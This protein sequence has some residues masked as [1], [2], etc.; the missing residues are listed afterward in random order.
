LGITIVRLPTIRTKHLE[1]LIHTFLSTIHACFSNCDVVHYYT[2]GP[3]LFSFVPRLFG[4]KTVV[5]VQG[6]DWQRKKWG[7]IARRALKFCEWT[8]ARLPSATVVVS[9]TLQEY[10]KSR[11]AKHCAYVS[12]GTRI[13]ERQTGNYLQ[14]IGLQPDSYALFLG[15]FSPE[16]NCDLLIEAFEKL[17]TTM[18]LV[19]AGGSSHTDDYVA[20]LRQHH[21]ER[22][23][24]LDWLSGDAL[25][26]VLTNAALFVLPSDME[27][28]SLALL[29]AM[30]AGLCVLASD[31]PE[32]VEAMGDAGFIFRRGD[33][34]D[35][36]RM[37]ALL[38][39]DPALRENIGCR[40][41]AR[42]RR[43]YLWEGVAKEMNGVYSSLFERSQ[44]MPAVKKKAAGKAA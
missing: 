40:A 14:S 10:Y 23:R 32:N 21:S 18:K 19:L 41:Q 35:L 16:K 26:E 2:L 7:R 34:N 5:S 4:K 8:S 44:R 33:V 30:G 38:L 3:S 31:A 39:S 1:T 42:S 9:R 43:E 25:E 17:D 27:G 29:D 28:L 6:L 24:I 22:I 11:Y 36:E 15:R 12:N 20:G 13:R 37:L